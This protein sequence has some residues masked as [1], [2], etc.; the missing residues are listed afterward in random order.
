MPKGQ[1]S[2]PN[3]R[4]CKDTYT[5]HPEVTKLLSSALDWEVGE[6][7]MATIY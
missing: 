6:S 5:L 7:V 4:G 3:S 2:L 1:K